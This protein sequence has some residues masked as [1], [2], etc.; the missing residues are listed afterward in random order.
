MANPNTAKRYAPKRPYEA[1]GST[2]SASEAER[3]A[4]EVKASGMDAKITRVREKW[5]T[6]H[7]TRFN[8]WKRPR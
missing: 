8:V 7:R 6:G 2:T 5:G 4:A 3:M 1:H